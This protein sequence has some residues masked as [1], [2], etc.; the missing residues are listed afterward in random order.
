MQ[1]GTVPDTPRP[2]D[3][4][5]TTPFTAIQFFSRPG[6]AAKALDELVGL[7]LEIGREFCS[8]RTVAVAVGA[9][10][11]A[12]ADIRLGERVRSCCSMRLNRPVSP[13]RGATVAPAS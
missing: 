13:W 8:D 6:A 5:I 10:S 2:A 11:T 7:G 9:H 4:R 3:C 1:T 12:R